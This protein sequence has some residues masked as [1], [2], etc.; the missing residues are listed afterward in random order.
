MTTKLTGDYIELY[1]VVDPG[2][3]EVETLI[4]LTHDSVDIGFDVT[5][6]QVT[7]HMSGRQE[8]KAVTDAVTIS[9]SGIV[10]TSLGALQTLGVLDATTK[11]ITG[12][13]CPNLE[14]LRIKVYSC[15]G[16]VTET[17]SWLALDV[18]VTLSDLSY[19]QGDFA[20]WSAEMMVNGT[21]TLESLP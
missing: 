10:V 14:G 9:I 3:T 11:A 13:V 16:D 19:A 1:K 2:G 5:T 8:S 20:T 12:F 4:G 7:P 18:V 17:Q 21:L 6:A 15:K